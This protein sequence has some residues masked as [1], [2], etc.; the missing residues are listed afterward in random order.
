MSD[1][2]K[3][4]GGSSGTRDVRPRV[5]SRLSARPDRPLTGSDPSRRKLTYE[6]AVGKRT[7]THRVEHQERSVR[8]LRSGGRHVTVVLRAAHEEWH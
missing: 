4:T 7:G 6:L 1:S 5:C 8:L 3:V 2:V